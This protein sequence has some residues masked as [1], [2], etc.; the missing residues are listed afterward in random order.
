MLLRKITHE[1]FAK[2]HRECH[3]PFLSMSVRIGSVIPLANCQNANLENEIKII[4]TV[5]RDR[6]LSIEI[7]ET[8]HNILKIQEK[9]SVRSFRLNNTKYAILTRRREN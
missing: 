8:I 6:K 4:R 7:L 2:C 3:Q 9:I 1:H 5:L